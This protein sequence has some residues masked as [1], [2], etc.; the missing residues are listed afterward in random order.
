MNADAFR[1]FYDYHFA[2]NRATWDKY[3]M[4]LSQEQFTQPSAEASAFSCRRHVISFA[5]RVA[6]SLAA[7][8]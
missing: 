6:T 8:R 7:A 1:H 3:V 2:E 5:P 4:A